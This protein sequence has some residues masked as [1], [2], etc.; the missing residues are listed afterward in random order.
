MNLE[1]D[2]DEALAPAVDDA[3][4]ARLD[5]A[6]LLGVYVGTLGRAPRG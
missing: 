4:K 3:G 2:P 6:A 5:I 1:L